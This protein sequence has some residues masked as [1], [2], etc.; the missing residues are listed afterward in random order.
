MT[1]INAAPMTAI[2]RTLRIPLNDDGSLPLPAFSLSPFDPEPGDEFEFSV[3]EEHAILQKVTRMDGAAAV[4]EDI[5]DPRG[6]PREYFADREDVR[7]FIEQER[8]NWDEDTP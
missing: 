4:A 5:P 3:D 8:G 2:I 7:R 1:A 6:L